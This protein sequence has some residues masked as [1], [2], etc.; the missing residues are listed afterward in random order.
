MG[1][2]GGA[3]AKE[4]ESTLDDRCSGVH[5]GRPWPSPYGQPAAVQIGYPAKRRGEY[6]V[7]SVLR[8]ALG[9]SMAL[10]LRA[11]CGCA[12]WLS[13]QFVEHRVLT[14]PLPTNKSKRGLDFHPSPFCFYLAVREG[15]EPSIRVSVYTL[16]RRAPSATQTPHRK[17]FHAV[18][19]LTGANVGKS[20][21][22][23]NTLL[24][25]SDRLLKVRAIC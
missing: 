22:S 14:G 18:A 13:C 1:N 24:Q 5:S 20:T 3:K 6:A 16:S 17:S 19:L 25:E 11:A 8:G 23:V 10:A 15:F 7:R 4:G 2:V 21:L 12:N 9:P